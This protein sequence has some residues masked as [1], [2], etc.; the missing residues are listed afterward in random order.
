MNKNHFET[1][2]VV[3]H[4]YTKIW[5]KIK[6]TAAVYFNFKN[7]KL[8]EKLFSQGHE[9]ANLIKNFLYFLK[10]SHVYYIVFI[11][12][13]ASKYELIF[14][15]WQLLWYFCFKM[16]KRNTFFELIIWG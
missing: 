13:Y 6:E 16:L 15:S 8:T 11:T 14:S 10:Q 9:Y 3:Q 2:H 5:R 7:K 12:K 1:W 4:I